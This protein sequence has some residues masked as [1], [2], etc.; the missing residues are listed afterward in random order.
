MP[1]VRKLLLWIN[2]CFITT[3]E[4][5]LSAN[6]NINDANEIFNLIKESCFSET[7]KD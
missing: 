7:K 6:I 4:L 1:A 2:D 5:F 3:I